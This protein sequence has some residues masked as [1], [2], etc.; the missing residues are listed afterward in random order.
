M[1]SCH[2]PHWHLTW[3][4]NRYFRANLSKIKF[5]IMLNEISW[6]QND[7]HCMIP[8]TWVLQTGPCFPEIHK[9]KSYPS[10]WWY[11][12][13]GTVRKWWR[14]NVVLRV[15][16]SSERLVLLG[17]EEE[18]KFLPLNQAMTQQEGKCLNDKRALTRNQSFDIGLPASRIVRSKCSLFKPPS[19]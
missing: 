4:W 13:I 18:S 19:P 2:L 15:E 9:S 5:H 3:I 8:L 16:P 6:S 12:K 1:F 7:K 14:L 10:L 11:L 17:K